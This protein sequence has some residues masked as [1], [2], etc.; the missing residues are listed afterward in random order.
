MGIRKPDTITQLKNEILHLQG[1]R[2][3]AS[4][5]AVDLM[6]GPVKNAFPDSSF[7]VGAIHEFICDKAENR[8]AT[9]GFI[10]GILVSLMQNGGACIWVGTSPLIFPPAL[11]L[12]GIEPD[13][14]IF[15][16]RGS[17]KE[18]LW[19]MEEALKCEGLAAVVGEISGLGFTASRRF[20]LA[21]EQSRVTGFVIR[22]DAANLS[23]TASVTRWRISSV[24]G[25]L[26]DDMPGVGFPCWDVELLKVRNG[27][28]GNWQMKWINGKMQPVY[29]TIPLKRELQRKTG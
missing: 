18:I 23:T 28:P 26:A 14:I 27:K 10:A 6:L 1:F 9:S 7:P 4:S 5:H 17:E 3:S 11:T 24:P 16:D 22:N 12:F 25:I 15:I 2:K 8:S 20:Q 13:K 29:T 19:I 21:T